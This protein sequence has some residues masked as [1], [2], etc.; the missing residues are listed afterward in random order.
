[1]LEE[2][3]SLVWGCAGKGLPE[4]SIPARKQRETYQKA[5]V[6]NTFYCQKTMYI[7]TGL[8]S[9]LKTGVAADLAQ[10]LVFARE[11][12]GLFKTRSPKCISQ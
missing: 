10:A 4:S 12:L 11:P 9:H 7:K 8:F 2:H 1:M 3:D 5:S 6:Q